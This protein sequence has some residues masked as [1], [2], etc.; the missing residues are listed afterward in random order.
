[1]IA[2]EKPGF[3]RAEV[4]LIAPTALAVSDPVGFA[5]ANEPTAVH[6][7]LTGRAGELRAMA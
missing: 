6:A 4:R 7:A 5:N 2:T 1:M 3:G